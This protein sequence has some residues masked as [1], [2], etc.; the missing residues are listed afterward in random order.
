VPEYLYPGVYVE[1]SDAAVH[2]IPGVSLDDA[3]LNRISAD[4]RRTMDVHAPGWTNQAEAD[5]GLTLV[6]LFAFLS[7]SLLFRAQ[8][9]PERGRVLAL[10]A[11]AALSALVQVSERECGGLKRPLYFSGRRLGA[12]TLMAEQ[13]YQ[14]EKRRRHNRELHGY[15]VVSGLGTSIESS[16]DRGGSRI[17]VEPGYAIDC[18][19]EEISLPLGATLPAP[20]DGETLFV[21]LRYWEHVCPPSPTAGENPAGSPT[22]EEA[23]VIGLSP[24]VVAPK[25]ALMRLLRFEDGWRVDPQFVTP[26]VLA[27]AVP[28]SRESSPHDR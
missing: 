6:E 18:Y 22:I 17:V 9:I 13:E 1:E 25:L 2:P 15:G 5:P 24:A 20:T 21:T 28:Q 8:Q 11:S 23:C 12:S 7:E 26:R 16:A 27:G 3:T 10:R 14:R 19:G 4:F